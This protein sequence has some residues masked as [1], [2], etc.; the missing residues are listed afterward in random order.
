MSYYESHIYSFFLM[1]YKHFYKE[2]LLLLDV[3]CVRLYLQVNLK[4]L[5]CHE[6]GLYFLSLISEI[7]THIVY[8]FITHRVKYFKPYFLKFR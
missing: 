1:H 3:Y 4:Q 5:E 6:K 7:E 8:R 2:S